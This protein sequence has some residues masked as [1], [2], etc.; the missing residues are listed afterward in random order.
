MKENILKKILDCDILIILIFIFILFVGILSFYSIKVTLMP[1]HTEPVLSIITEYYG[2]EPDIIEEIITK[3][4]ENLLKDVEGIKDFYSFSYMGRSKIVVYL[5]RGEDVDKKAVLIK[6]KIYYISNKFP[7]EVHEPAI[8]KYNTEDKPVV[9]ISLSSQ[10]HPVDELYTM[11]NNKIKPEL[12]SINGIANIEI[13]GSSKQEYIIEQNYENITRLGGNYESIFKEIVKNNVSVPVGNITDGNNLINVTYPNRYKSLISLPYNYYNFDNK[14]ISGKDLFSIKKKKRENERI[15]LIDNKPALTLYIFK[16]DFSN[17]LEIEK[18]VRGILKGW[19]NVLSY[20]CIFNQAENFRNL[21]EQLK[22]ALITS[23]LCVFV[24]V[25]LFY[26]RLFLSFIVIITIPICLAGTLLFLKLFS[27]SLNIMTLSGIIVG[28]GISV[29]NTIIMIEAIKR[30][31]S[32]KTTEKYLFISMEEIN[33][34]ILASTLTTIAVF[35]PLFY[36]NSSIISLYA[37]FALSISI[38]LLMS[39]LTSILFIP[40]FIKRFYSKRIMN[41]SKRKWKRFKILKNQKLSS[42]SK[43]IMYLPLFIVKK[44]LDHPIISLSIFFIL[45]G[46]FVYLFVKLE[47]EDILPLK[48]REIELYYEFEP[49]YNNNYMKKIMID[50]GNEILNMRLPITLISRLDGTKA[51]F[52]L[53]FNNNY[54]NYKYNVKCVKEYFSDIRRKDGFFYFQR[55]KESGVKSLTIHFFGDNLKNLDCFVDS[56]SKGISGLYGTKKVLKGYKKGKPEIMLNVDTDRMYYYNL[57]NSD[58]IRFLRYIFYYPVIMKYYEDDNIVDVR[59]KIDIN[60]LQRD[61]IHSINIPNEKGEY[62]PLSDFSTYN[63][64][65]SAGCITRKNG[66]RYIPIDIRYE[67]VKEAPL[68]SSIVSWLKGVA[69]EKDFYYEF[70]EKIV[71][72]RKNKSIFVFTLFLALFIVYI[73]LGLILKSFKYPFIIILSPLSIFVGS[74][75]FLWSNGYG[76]SVPAHIAIIM[77]VGL[78]VN[79]FILLL[80]EALRIKKRDHKTAILLSY[81]RKMRLIVITFLTTIFSLIPV[82]VLSTST[83]FFKILTGVMF[84]GMFFGLIISLGI[85]PVFYLLVNRGNKKLFR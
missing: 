81:K 9:I 1:K 39:Y 17:I 46:T 8:Y 23:V 65:D 64:S 41:E 6:D 70:D 30:N 45:I 34:P 5:N 63:Y 44:Y 85:F 7:E 76:R 20:K 52:L 27:K 74:F 73:I 77:L 50:I 54:K 29:D 75:I 66:K 38:M 32:Y 84:S 53:K 28:I 4:I 59:G 10:K 25:I 22:I 42:I 13:A 26:K 57:N 43:K 56:V 47:Y 3:P 2:I 62:I 51:T 14:F 12:L 67:G 40:S 61:S 69:F 82:F 21:L 36:I 37:D 15:S 31:K 60:P 71:E 80:G 24:I 72:N 68:M 58:V 19:V 35:F 49:R 11:V 18:G 55:G 83:Y 79:S 16:K 33:K 78:S 48:E